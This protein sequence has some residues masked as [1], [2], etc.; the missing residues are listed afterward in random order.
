MNR[1]RFRQAL[2]NSAGRNGAGFSDEL[3]TRVMAGVRHARAEGQA[4]ADASAPRRIPW[5]PLA[6]VAAG[7]V[8]LAIGGLTLLRPDQSKTSPS[9]NGDVA[10][11]P[12]IS[13]LRQAVRNT[14]APVRDR[15]HDARYA[16]LDRDGKRLADFLARSLPKFPSLPADRPARSAPSDPQ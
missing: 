7:V 12:S 1:D 8:V 6:T 5:L 16:Y 9:T 10:V 11:T 4:T 14:A 13:D 3:H 2:R 15:M